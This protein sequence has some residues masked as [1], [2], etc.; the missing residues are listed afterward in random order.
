LLIMAMGPVSVVGNQLTSLGV[1]SQANPFSILAG[2]VF[3]FNLGVSSDLFVKVL[4]G[5]MASLYQ[6][7]AKKTTGDMSGSNASGLGN[8][9]MDGSYYHTTSGVNYTTK[10][11]TG[12][13]LQFLFYLPSGNV[14]FSNNQT[15]LEMRDFE[16][17]H[18]ISSQ[19]IFSLDDISYVGNQ[20]Q[21]STFFD[22]VLSDVLIAG[23]TVRTNDNRYQEGFTVT[24]FSLI[25][26]GILMNTC[27]S[28]QATHCLIPVGILFEE[29]IDNN[30]VMYQQFLNFE[31][32]NCD[33]IHGRLKRYLYS[34]A[35]NLGFLKI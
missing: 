35:Q 32:M 8:A 21:C 29:K 15:T 23:A 31:A 10:P 3:I 14:L 4:L 19:L 26:V 28:N 34:G 11:T 5:R 13:F 22:F 25:S 20:S 24:P 12:R 6:T 2:S 7:R 17:S 9:N 27:T 1:D 30:L 18:P 33:S 16:F